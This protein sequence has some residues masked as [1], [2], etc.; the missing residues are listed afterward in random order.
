MAATP[1]TMMP[2]GT[3]APDFT[4]LDTIS[5]EIKSLGDLKGAAGTLVV[6][7]CNHCPYVLHVKSQLI[8]IAQAYASQGIATVAMSANDIQ[9]YPDDAPDKMHILMAEWGN[10]F[11]AY[12]YDESQ[13]VAKAYQAACTPDIYLFDADLACVYRGR[14]DGATPK[15]DVPLTGEDLRHAL[16][17]LL[18]GKPVDAN[19]LPSIG[20]NIKWKEA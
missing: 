20:C 5:G 12:L 14:L 4:L 13:S 18:A 7:M 19:Q 10:P 2:L 17:N 11:T 15:N 16:D 3:I 6:F 8:V 1:S 9:N